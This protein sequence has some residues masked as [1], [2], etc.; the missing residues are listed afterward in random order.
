MAQRGAR[1]AEVDR[2]GAR[3]SLLDMRLTRAAAH[4]LNH[5]IACTHTTGNHAIILACELPAVASLV[6][7][8]LSQ[9]SKHFG[10]NCGSL[11]RHAYQRLAVALKAQIT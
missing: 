6:Y 11:E 4:T 10:E 1:L 9:Q 3:H 7:Y 8:F 2:L 5:A